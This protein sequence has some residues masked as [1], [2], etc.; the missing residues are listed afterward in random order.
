MLTLGDDVPKCWNFPGHLASAYEWAHLYWPSPT[1]SYSAPPGVHRLWC[2]DQVIYCSISATNTRTMQINFTPNEIN[3]CHIALT[4]EM[5]HTWFMAAREFSGASKA[6]PLLTI[7]QY[8]T[9]DPTPFSLR[10]SMD[11]TISLAGHLSLTNLDAM[12]TKK[13]SSISH[14]IPTEAKLQQSQRALN[15]NVRHVVKNQNSW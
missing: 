7:G 1:L 15:R 3:E 2:W 8:S 5:T 12:Q 4:M 10:C 9:S 13:N 6:P 14:G 11:C